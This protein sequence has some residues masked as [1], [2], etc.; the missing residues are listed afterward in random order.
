MPPILVIDSDP[1]TRAILVH[2]VEGL[3]EVDQAPTGADAL[4]LLAAK[5]FAVVLLDLH[6]RPLDGFVILRTLA[7]RDGPNRQ[8][9]VYAIATDQA[10][11]ARALRERAV[12]ALIKPVNGATVTNLVDAWL[13]KTSTDEG[14]PSSTARA[15]GSTLPPRTGQPGGH[16]QTVGPSGRTTPPLRPSLPPLVPA[17]SLLPPPTGRSVTPMPGSSRPSPAMPRSVTPPPGSTPAPPATITSTPPQRTR[18]LTP[19]ADS[20][21]PPVPSD[22]PESPA[23]G[24]PQ[25]PGTSPAPRN[26]TP[27]P[28]SAARVP[29]PP[30]SSPGS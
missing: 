4:R 10:E 20:T 22:A 9:P 21:K 15:K 11:Q 3:G 18:S 6:V 26:L 24:H 30:P 16:P 7:A 12:F 19:S 13:R 23:G 25:A 1:G 2:A 8:T 29:K 5:P 17:P 14:P 27:A 28:A